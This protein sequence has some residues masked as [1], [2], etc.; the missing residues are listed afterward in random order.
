[1]PASATSGSPLGT[2]RFLT[3]A[4]AKKA[5]DVAMS[6]ALAKGYPVSVSVVDRDGIVIA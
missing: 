3:L 1:M 5:A 6:S 2:T 4:A